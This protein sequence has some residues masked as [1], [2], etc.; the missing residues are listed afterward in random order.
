MSRPR[1]RGSRSGEALYWI[2]GSLLIVVTLAAVGGLVF[3]K[4][5]AAAHVQR[6]K[7]TLC[8]VD[9]PEA[10]TVVLLDATDDL[11]EP[12]KIQ[13]RTRLV[14]VAETL[15]PNEQL[16]LRILSPAEPGG[17]RLFLKC[18]PGDGLG[19]SE[20][21]DNPEMA[22]RRWLREFRQP[23]DSA[24]AEI[25][26]AE[27]ATSPIMKAIQRIA[28]ESFDG[29]RRADVP[30]RL[31]IVS[32]MI[33]HDQDYS[34]YTGDLSYERFQASPAYK[35][36]RTDLDDVEVTIEYLQRLRPKLDSGQHIEFWR[37]WV[38]E[39]KGRLVNA[40]KMQGAS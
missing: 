21:T 22:R 14:D 37:K 16:E 2:V 26:P 1:R 5:S 9:G 35:K 33:E 24:L 40:E 11:P 25:G 34:Q 4:L 38:A 6:S 23:L 36:L 29:R 30:K 10:V 15:R 8:P 12:S 18:N 31:I 19:L 32:D 28:L 13:L 27:A 3:V 20:W 17:V 7:D 39:N